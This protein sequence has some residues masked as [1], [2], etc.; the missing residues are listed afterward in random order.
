MSHSLV[1]PWTVPRQAPLSMGYSKNSKN[2]RLG[3]HFLLQGIFLTQ[4]LS[5]CLLQLLYLRRILY[6]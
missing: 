3:C 4:R 6:C 1:T 2:S 5:L